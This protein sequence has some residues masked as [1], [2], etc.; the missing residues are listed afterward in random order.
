MYSQVVGCSG[1]FQVLYVAHLQHFCWISLKCSL[2]EMNFAFCRGAPSLEAR[3]EQWTSLHH[4]AFK[5]CASW[6]P[7]LVVFWWRTASCKQVCLGNSCSEFLKL[8]L[9]FLITLFCCLILF[10][11]FVVEPCSQFCY[12]CIDRFMVFL[13]WSR[14]RWS[15]TLTL[16]FVL[17]V[18]AQR[19]ADA[20]SDCWQLCELAVD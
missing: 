13:E 12:L 9:A 17:V 6:F 20:G 18:C 14:V 10:I 4:A 5:S 7:C 8:H 16:V 2:F 11:W 15:D 19:R 3:L 1:I